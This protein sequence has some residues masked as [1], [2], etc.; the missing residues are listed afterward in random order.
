[1]SPLAREHAKAFSFVKEWLCSLNDIHCAETCLLSRHV[2]QCHAERGGRNRGGRKQMRANANKRGQTLTNANKRRGENA[3]KRKQ[4]RA[5]ADKRKQ[6]LTPPFIVVSYT[7]LCNPLSFV[8]ILT[9]LLVLFCPTPTFWAN[10]QGHFSAMPNISTSFP[11]KT[12]KMGAQSA[13][14]GVAGR[15]RVC[16]VFPQKTPVRGIPGN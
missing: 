4:T 13:E 11:P 9:T 14:I 5:N 2:F 10:L 1:M 15:F 8:I 16:G 3:S 6:T 7:P 12:L